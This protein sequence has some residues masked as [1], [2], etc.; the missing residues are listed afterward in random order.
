MKDL[1]NVYLKKLLLLLVE[2]LKY[3]LLARKK[4]LFFM[5]P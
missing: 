3:G 1:Y 5:I 2:Y 4:S